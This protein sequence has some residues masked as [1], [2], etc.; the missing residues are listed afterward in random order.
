MRQLTYG[1]CS[2]HVRT[3]S[4]GSQTTYVRHL[5][6]ATT[7][8]G[9]V[10]PQLSSHFFNDTPPKQPPTSD[11]QNDLGV[12][13]KGGPA[14][15]WPKRRF[16]ILKSC[17]DLKE[18]RPCHIR[19]SPRLP[20]K[21]LD[22][23]P[24]ELIG[25]IISHFHHKL[26]SQ[27]ESGLKAHLVARKALFKLCRTS[28]SITTEAKRYLYGTIHVSKFSQLA[29]LMHTLER[30]PY[31]RSLIR[32]PAIDIAF[33]CPITGGV[34]PSMAGA[35]AWQYTSIYAQSLAAAQD[36]FPADLEPVNPPGPFVDYC[37][38]SQ[39]LLR[40]LLHFTPLL[41]SLDLPTPQVPWGHMRESLLGYALRAQPH[42]CPW[43]N[44]RIIKV[45]G[46]G[47]N[48]RVKELEYWPLLAGRGMRRIELCGLN[49]FFDPA[50]WLSPPRRWT[51]CTGSRRWCSA[52]RSLTWS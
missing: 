12:T 28:H 13:S 24:P 2:T 34:I 30:T 10:R 16:M 44:L 17:N 27:S 40:N 25:E 26:N 19:L 9:L 38:I 23:L 3:I 42:G 50:R 6:S 21:T 51:G 39:I 14:S 22:T 43:A 49:R 33:V 18:K 15:S 46:R 36:L 31:L 41:E 29:L 11:L 32:H 35:A 52:G 37:H 48:S 45:H 7:H 8:F 20:L 4:E 1:R 5:V 47:N